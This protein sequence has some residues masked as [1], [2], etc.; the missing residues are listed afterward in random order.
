MPAGY[1]AEAIPVDYLARGQ[2]HCLARV[3]AG[4]EAEEATE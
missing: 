3:D 4:I 2:Q 1:C